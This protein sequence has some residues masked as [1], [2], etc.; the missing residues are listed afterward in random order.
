MDVKSPLSNDKE[1][2]LAKIFD[3][4]AWKSFHLPC[5]LIEEFNNFFGIKGI[6]NSIQIP[7]LLLKPLFNC[8]VLYKLIDESGKLNRILELLE[9]LL[10]CNRISNKKKHGT[11][12]GGP[13]KCLYHTLTVQLFFVQPPRRWSRPHEITSIMANAQQQITIKL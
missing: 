6:T 8:P 11:L 3:M 13:S 12:T 1:C 10:L 2:K 4:R 7:K 9:N 5:F